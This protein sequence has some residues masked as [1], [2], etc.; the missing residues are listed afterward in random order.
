MNKRI[1]LLGLTFFWIGMA[2]GAPVLFLDSEPTNPGIQSNTT[3]STGDAFSVDVL[4]SG[5]EAA[6]PLNG[7]D[8]FILF[9]S[10]VLNATNIEDG[11]FLHSPLVAIP[12]IDNATGTIRFAEASLGSITALGDG[13]LASIDFQAMAAGA[14]SLDFADVALSGLFGTRIDVASTIGATI[15]VSSPSSVPEPSV[16]G[17]LALGALGLIISKRK[18]KTAVVPA[19]G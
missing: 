5:V 17:L 10:I 13:V 7:F 3:I 15:N 8:L 4:I 19:P 18:A 2:N 14:T 11:G 6:E 16:L 12:N 9:D 1:L